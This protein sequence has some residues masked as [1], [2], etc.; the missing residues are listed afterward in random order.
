M[1][2]IFFLI[3]F[4]VSISYT[5]LAQRVSNVDWKLDESSEKITIIYD[6]NKEGENLYYD[7]AMKVIANGKTI[8]P[9][10]T[11]MAGEIGKFQRFGKTKKIVWDVREYSEQLE[12]ASIQFQITASAATDGRVVN[13]GK[14]NTDVKPKPKNLPVYAGLG[15]VATTGLGLM[16]GGITTQ[17][18]AKEDYDKSL[19]EINAKNLTSIE[20]QNEI[21]DAYD[22]FNPKY[23]K[24]QGL[25]YG[26]VGVFA[27]SA[28][29]IVYR[30][31]WNKKLQN[32]MG[33]IYPI[34]E[35]NYAQIN[36][37]TIPISM[38]L[39]LGFARRF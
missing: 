33:G 37:G 20:K 38:T 5:I 14:I 16:I 8:S 19:L 21:D 12:G 11:S 28:G 24:G 13:D 3:T 22:D 15:T 18:N 7:I 9:K 36:K 31:Y 4:C 23:K 6:L 30:I 25:L 35:P 29:I 17:N 26:G 39:G 34:I 2:K 32:R 10:S 1:K 27:V